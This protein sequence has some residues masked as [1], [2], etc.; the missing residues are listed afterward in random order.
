MI[1]IYGPITDAT[2][3][4]LEKPLRLLK[5]S[6]ETKALVLRVD[7]PGGV[8]TACETIHQQLQDLPQKVVVS[9]GNVSASGGYYIS[10]NSDRI[11]ASPTTITG[12]IGVIMLRTDF[13]GLAKQ[14]GVTFDSVSSSSLAGSFDPFY[15]MNSQMKENFAN[16]T[17]RSYKHFKAVVSEGRQLDMDEVEK[18]AQGRVW[19]GTQAKDIG[20]VDEL[21]GLDRA[22]A[23]CQRNFTQSGNAKVVAWPPKKSIFQAFVDSRK[24]GGDDDSDL[25]NV[26]I[27]SMLEVALAYVPGFLGLMHNDLADS[28][29]SSPKE[30]RRSFEEMLRSGDMPMVLT[31]AMMTMDE[32]AAIQ[33]LLEQHEV[34]DLLPGTKASNLTE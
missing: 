32:N 19:T 16:F 7:S 25:D 3:R 27:P 34:N 4:K 1:K 8:V 31:G 30:T 2:A 6:K 11:F 26:E 20:L 22:V 13:R 18:V 29:L 10:A 9:F 24:K 15:P 5:K 33:C 23:Y 12:S 28:M 14:W 17:D 21:G